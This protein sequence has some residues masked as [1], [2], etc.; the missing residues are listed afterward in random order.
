[1]GD[2]SQNSPPPPPPPSPPLV[3]NVVPLNTVPPPLITFQLKIS[4]KLDEK[5]FL[6][7]RQ[8]IEPVV[9]AQNLQSFLY[10]AE[11]PDEFIKDSITNSF[12]EN[13]VYRTW[14]QQDQ[15]LL[16]WLQSTILSSVVTRILGCTHASQ[17]W[18]RIQDHFQKLTHARVRQLRSELRAT[19]LDDRYVDDYLQRIKHLVDSLASVGDSIPSQQHIDVI[20]EEL[21][22]DYGPVMSVIESKFEDI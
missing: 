22:R 4:E 8:Q 12:Y 20:L 15:W 11:I 6:M 16:S 19:T 1:M 9:N 14:I 18:Q 2:S 17:L 7:W 10:Y 21:P 3:H 13:P 5:N